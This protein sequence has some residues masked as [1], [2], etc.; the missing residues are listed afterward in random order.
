MVSAIGRLEMC[1]HHLIRQLW[2]GRKPP[3]DRLMEGHM[4]GKCIHADCP[5]QL[6]NAACFDC[7]QYPT[8]RDLQ[9]KLKES[10]RTHYYQL[11]S[12]VYESVV[13]ITPSWNTR[14]LQLDGYQR[15]KACHS[16]SQHKYVVNSIHLLNTTNQGPARY[17]DN[18]IC[19]FKLPSS[20]FQQD[21]G[22]KFKPPTPCMFSLIK[23]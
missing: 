23:F 10:S 18:L 8:C 2:A 1:W 12:G 16:A 17:C 9:Q 22:R 3:K 6:A 21:G 15:P 11:Q 4:Q 7:H 13:Q 20:K 5:P 14:V 19:I